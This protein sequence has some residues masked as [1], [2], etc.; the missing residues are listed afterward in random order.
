[1][2][3]PGVGKSRLVYEFTR[4][5]RTQGWLILEAGSVSYGKATSYLPV[6]DLLKGYF[7]VQARDDLREIRER[8]AGKILMLDRVREPLLTPLLALLDVPVDD[9]AWSA[10]DPPQRRQRTLEAVKQLLL[11]ESQVQPLLLIFEDLHWI[12]SE[13]QSLLDGLVES[14]P[15]ARIL[16]IV[17]YRPE[18]QHAWGGKTYYT[19]LLIDELPPASAEELLNTLLGDHPGLAPLKQ[20]LIARIEGNPFFLEEGVC[21]LLETGVLVGELG[22]Y[23]LGKSLD[24]L[25][26]PATVRGLSSCRRR[27][28]RHWSTAR[29]HVL[30]HHRY[31][32]IRENAH[33]RG[34]HPTQ[35]SCSGRRLAQWPPRAATLARFA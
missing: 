30:S 31:G 14:L 35:T 33:V 10:L 23:R 13:T 28:P 29:E 27:P 34:S 32:G 6:I 2:G 15:T 21:T 22:A 17:N 16:L 24:T 9:E 25:R 3:E 5:H 12:D 19:Q 26:V 7:K 11:R 18:Y 8:V 4:S 1:V 20:L